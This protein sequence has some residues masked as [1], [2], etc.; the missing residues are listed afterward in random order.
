VGVGKEE[1]RLN[2]I[3]EVLS[4]FQDLVHH[5]LPF[6]LLEVLPAPRKGVTRIVA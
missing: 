3:E 2:R 1:S 5:Q 4:T 6:I